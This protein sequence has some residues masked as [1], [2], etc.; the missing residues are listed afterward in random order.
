MAKVKKHRTP[1]PDSLDS[2]WWWVLIF[3]ILFIYA[4]WG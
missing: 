4:I 2:G 3:V 1:K